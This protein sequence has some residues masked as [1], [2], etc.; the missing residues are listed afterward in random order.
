MNMTC[1]QTENPNRPSSALPDAVLSSGRS[2]APVGDAQ[3]D[4]G[5]ALFRRFAAAQNPLGRFLLTVHLQHQRLRAQVFANGGSVLKRTFDVVASSI[6]LLMFSPLLAVIAAVI[7]VQDGGSIF[8]PQTRV[9]Q[10]GKEFKMF[11]FRSMCLDAEARLQA[12]LAQNAHADGVTFKMQRDPRITP[13]GRWLRKLSLDELPQLF[14]V[15]IG[16]MSLVG[17]RP[18]VPREVAKYTLADR[19]RLAVKPGITCIWQVSG[20]SQIDFTGQVR[21]DVNYIERQSFWFDLQLLFRTIP[22]VVFARGAC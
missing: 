14:N 13:A 7:W 10:N 17:P 15:L 2:L 5:D 4:M 9:G 19:R 8:F 16:D 11:K 1:S 20:R 3:V 22:A 12:L 6:L 18:P 21:L